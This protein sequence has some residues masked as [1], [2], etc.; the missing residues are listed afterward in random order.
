PPTNGAVVLT[1]AKYMPVPP[2][3]CGSNRQQLA[4]WPL[5]FYGSRP[6]VISK[7]VVWRL[8]AWQV[9]SARPAVSA[10]VVVAIAS[11]LAQPATDSQNTPH[12]VAR[13]KIAPRPFAAELSQGA[14]VASPG[15]GS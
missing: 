1:V 3:P 12:P 8:G 14:Q 7:P 9:L 10:A 5:E 2:I 13:S 4:K 15:F 11:P 6:S